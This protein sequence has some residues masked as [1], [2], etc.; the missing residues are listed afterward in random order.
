MKN[1]ETPFMNDSWTM[2]FQR[3]ERSRQYEVI[4][5]GEDVAFESLK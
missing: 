2:T 4:A 3:S 1:V 5:A